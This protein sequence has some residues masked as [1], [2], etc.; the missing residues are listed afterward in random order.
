MPVEQV[1]GFWDY[2]GQG[3]QRGV[4]M[5]N[6]SEDKKR[7][8]AQAN[9][10]VMGQL[11]QSGAVDASQLQGA[12]TAAG[13]SPK[14]V[15]QPNI[16]Q[17]RRTVE[18]GGQAAIDALPDYMKSKLGYTTDAQKVTEQAKMSGEQLDI[19]KNSEMKNYLTTGQM[20][21]QGKKAWGMLSDSDEEMK[22]LTQMDPYLKNQG[23]LYVA[24]VMN[25]SGG[26]IDPK[27]AT[28]MGE[29]AYANY[30]AARGQHIPGVMSPEQVQ[31]TRMYFQKA[32]D[33]ALIAQRDYDIKKQ[34]ATS[35]QTRAGADMVHAN[36]AK[37]AAANNPQMR[38][39]TQ[40]TTALED[41]RK[42]QQDLLKE[43][44]G[45]INALGDPKLASS[46]MMIGAV[47]R[48][49]A[50]EQQAKA[51]KQGQSDL[52]RDQV[53][54]NMNQLLDAAS[55][56]GTTQRGVVP[57]APATGNGPPAGAPPQGG[58]PPI[59]VNR[60]V[61]IIMSKQGTLEGLRSHVAV[62]KMSQQQFDQIAAAVKIAQKQAT[63]SKYGGAAKSDSP[64]VR[65]P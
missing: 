57:A 54:G 13:V 38:W 58:T 27:N 6:I 59:D 11:F 12:L 10:G 32:V 63:G 43:S 9:A 39:F 29:T 60:A 4:Q 48:Y 14:V 28:Q 62:G 53:P 42:S 31:N 47:T 56:N 55:A 50:L 15:I 51:F 23:E 5:H 33:N 46:P 40:I 64:I 61:Q 20:S 34:N 26:R 30:V 8:D 22:K 25:A 24:G 44:P 1:P 16:A 37:A 35:E 65:R 2:L 52:S 49:N 18:A 36:A 41:V 7:A 45:L 21:P 17:Q 19:L 3:I